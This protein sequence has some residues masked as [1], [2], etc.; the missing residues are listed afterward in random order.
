MATRYHISDSGTPA[1]CRAKT[2]E[3]CPKTKAGDG[4]HGTLEE[5]TAE[6]EHRLETAYGA[7]VTLASDDQ[8]KLWD[9]KSNELFIRVRDYYRSGGSPEQDFDDVEA[10]AESMRIQG[11]AEIHGVDP[12]SVRNSRGSY[13]V[14]EADGTPRVYGYRSAKV[15]LGYLGVLHPKLDG[16]VIQSSEHRAMI[17]NREATPDEEL[18]RHDVER[19]G[20]ATVELKETGESYSVTTDLEGNPVDRP[21]WDFIGDTAPRELFEDGSLRAAIANGGVIKD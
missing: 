9:Q 19:F 12:R 1:V 11:L 15:P 17:G 20:Y 4:F 21:V 14:E 16:V 8:R 13:I 18:F 6:S 10:Q 7:T 5:A 2:V 3:S